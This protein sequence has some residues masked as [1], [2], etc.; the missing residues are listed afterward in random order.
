MLRGRLLE[1]SSQVTLYHD[2]SGRALADYSRLVFEKVAQ[3]N[4]PA[5]DQ[6]T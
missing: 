6:Q 4:R 2:D 5:G 3:N 1:C